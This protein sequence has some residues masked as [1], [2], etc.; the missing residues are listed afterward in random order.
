MLSIIIPAFNEEKRILKTLKNI[1]NFKKIN[2]K[3]IE[4]IIIDDWSFDNTFKIVKKIFWVKIIKNLK[5]LWKWFSLKKWIL[6]AKW[7]FILIMDADLST[8]V[9]EI[10]KLEKYIQNNDIIIW[11]RYVFWS[12]IIKKQNFI[13][14]IISRIG[15]IFIKKLFN[16]NQNDTQCW[17]KL[18]KAKTAKEII[19]YQKINRFWW[20]IEFLVL[21]NLFWY[22]ILEVWIDWEDKKWS[23]FRIFSDTFKTILEIILI[24]INYIKLKKDLWKK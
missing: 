2:N 4:I 22:K 5:N 24:Y 21:A 16:I 10:E 19:K 17:F 7:E 8:K 18:F 20:D 11:S 13:R 23:K 14:K 1:S 12:K 9:E 6:E 3:N 15:N